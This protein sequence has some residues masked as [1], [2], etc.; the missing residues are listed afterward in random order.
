[1]PDFA[2]LLPPNASELERIIEQATARTVPVDIKT[3]WN[4]E[5]IPPNLMAWLAWEWSVDSWDSGWNNETKRRVLAKSADYHRKKG[6]RQSV[7]EAI[8]ALGSNIALKE[9]FEY[10]PPRNPYTFDVVIDA[11]AGGSSGVLQGQLINAIDQAKPVRSHYTVSV[12]T[13]A[14]A[15]LS[16]H[17]VVRIGQ[18]IR[19]SLSDSL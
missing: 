2:S 7:I 8:R 17:G 18:F 16:I 14:D 3:W 1:M 13:R 10:S 9:W 12:A 11:L 15:H 19:L 6:T 4:P 5:K